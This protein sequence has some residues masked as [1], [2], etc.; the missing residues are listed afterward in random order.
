MGLM[1]WLGLK[2]ASPKYL[3]GYATVGQ[4]LPVYDRYNQELNINR[5]VTL[6]DV[7]SIVR[8]IAKTAAQIPVRVY[9]VKDQKKFRKYQYAIKSNNG[10]PASIVNMKL[11]KEAALEEVGQGDE[12]QMLLDNPNPLYTRSEFLEGWFTMRMI[13]GN[14]YVYN[15]RLEDGVNKGKAVEMWLMPTQYTNPVITQTFPKEITRYQLRLFGI[16]D[17]DIADVMHSRYFNP[18][19]TVMGD[20][21]IGLSPLQALS[22]NAQKGQ[23]EADYTVGA[24]QNH[25]SNG[26]LSFEELDE[27][28]IESIGKMKKDYYAET[29]GVLNAMKTFWTNQKVTYTATGLSPV[30]MQVIESQMITLKKF[31]NAYGVSA[32]LFNNDGTGSIVSD[33]NAVKG[34]YLNAVIP[35]VSAWCDIVNK[36]LAPAYGENYFVDYDI[37]E[38]A[39]LQTDMKLLA[40]S[41]AAMW[42]VTPNEKRTVQN[43]EALQDENMNKILV[44]SGLQY[45]EDLVPVEPI[46]NTADDYGA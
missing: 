16:A 44:P 17:I 38:V 37:T 12:L 36:D 5:Y 33:T 31:C 3:T 39:E 8:R 13:A 32:R 29:T 45:L 41:L 14:S 21:L 22:R 9:T 46:D 26:V 42:W 10:T 27:S 1:Q 40:E 28:S 24:F 18:Q 11:L 35:E 19:F 6:E 4:G 34:L 20:E 23:S 30:D 2:K 25:G 43:F 7:Y 15:P